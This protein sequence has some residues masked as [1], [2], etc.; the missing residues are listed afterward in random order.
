MLENV[1]S[2]QACCRACRS[3]GVATANVWNYCA[4]PGGCIYTLPN[5]KAMSMQAGQCELR[6]NVA[7]NLA[8]GECCC[9]PVVSAV[10]ARAAL[11][12]AWEGA[13]L[14]RCRP[15]VPWCSRLLGLMGWLTLFHC[16]FTCPR[17]W[18]PA[19]CGCQRA[20]G[21]H[22]EARC[23]FQRGGLCDCSCSPRS[24]VTCRCPLTLQVPFIGGSPIA[25][26]AAPLQGYEALLGAFMYSDIGSFN[27]SESIRRGLLGE[28][29]KACR[30]WCCLSGCRLQAQW[31]DAGAAAVPVTEPC[32][33][34]L[35]PP[36]LLQ[37]HAQRMLVGLTVCS[38]GSVGGARVRMR[39]G[40][41]HVQGRAQLFHAATRLPLVC[42][43]AQG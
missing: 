15:H 14:S 26:V 33:C 37:A 38:S 1:P 22:A 7:A 30:A 25:V 29:G 10:L 6:Y 23:Y 24:P 27:C 19:L 17:R 35:P 31:L 3:K 36:C 5:G 40:A 32:A 4:E 9:I 28:C 42:R 21:V 43:L 16:P 39:C 34:L 13:V 12:E 2:P 20:P 18:F 11:S 41:V 8:M